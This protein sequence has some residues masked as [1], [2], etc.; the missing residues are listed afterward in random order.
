VPKDNRTMSNNYRKPPVEYQFKKG[1][2]GNPR[3]R[4]KKKPD[5]SGIGALGGGI[6][7]RFSAMA[8]EE[9]A[10]PVTVREGE[11]SSEMPAMQAVLR[12]MF[13]AAAKGDAKAA[14]QLLELI[15]RAEAARSSVA[16]EILESADDYKKRKLSLL[17]A[18]EQAG[19]EPPE[20]YPHPD[21]VI[22][23][24]DTGEVKIDG[25]TT[26]EQA[27]ARK[28][29]RELALK[30]MR[31]YFEV[32]AA[33]EKEPKNRELKR[34]FKELKKYLDFLKADSERNTRLEALR[35]ARRSLESK[36]PGPKDDNEA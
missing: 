12:T 26:K 6:A 11:K 20:I 30:S 33:L 1:R 9:A 2:S 35:V 18:H 25:P 27:G 22:I 7:D 28:A 5:P 19:A 13:R 24:E 36:P 23:D 3:G 15:A 10:R 4:P 31:R 32:E 21:D 29:I 17:E 16:M 14:R 34:E 8:L